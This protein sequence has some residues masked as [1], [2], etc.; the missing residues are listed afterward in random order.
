MAASPETQAYVCIA[1]ESLFGSAGD[2]ACAMSCAR[3]DIEELVDSSYTAVFTTSPGPLWQCQQSPGSSLLALQDCKLWFLF[4]D[5]KN[6]HS[7]DDNFTSRAQLLAIEKYPCVLVLF[8]SCAAGPPPS[9]MHQIYIFQAKGCFE[10]LAK[11]ATTIDSHP[12][13]ED[14]TMSNWYQ[15]RRIRYAQLDKIK[16]PAPDP[17]SHM[18]QL[19]VFP[20]GSVVTVREY[21]AK[22]AAVDIGEK[23]D[24]E[25]FKE[26]V[27]AAATARSTPLLDSSLGLSGPRKQN[28]HHIER[29][30]IDDNAYHAIQMIFFNEDLKSR[31]IDVPAERLDA[32]RDDLRVANNTNRAWL[33]HRLAHITG[34]KN[35][36]KLAGR[37]SFHLP[38]PDLEETF[39]P[40]F[41]R[42]SPTQRQHGEYRGTCQLCHAKDS[43]LAALLHAIDIDIDDQEKLK[44]LCLSDIFNPLLVCDAC[45]FHFPIPNNLLLDEVVVAV[46][47]LVSIMD[48]VGAWTDALGAAL[49]WSFA[50]DDPLPAFA[51]WFRD[52]RSTFG[53]AEETECAGQGGTFEGALRWVRKNIEKW[54][55]I[56]QDRRASKTQIS[57]V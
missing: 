30:D 54:I 41:V 27:A 1:S 29:V 12:P 5:G 56:T 21:L 14:W 3:R 57:D 42:S 28:E 2:I 13:E 44:S 8:G 39:V 4:T 19:T 49:G 51:A 50:M 17:M 15:L 37:K 47:P 45:A 18:D 9:T 33:H 53:E 52:Q 40:G 26:I 46:L 31:G 35:K 6:E 55:S 16:L 25:R 24:S 43:L 48:N 38:V 20:T 34:Q 7:E 11:D 36:A 22:M 23:L 32:Y 10:S